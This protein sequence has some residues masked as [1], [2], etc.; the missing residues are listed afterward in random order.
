ME[1]RN[2]G[3]APRISTGPG[4]AGRD[5]PEHNLRA[6]PD[7]PACGRDEEIVSPR[8]KAVLAKRLSRCTNASMPKGE[9]VRHFQIN[10]I[11]ADHVAAADE[12]DLDHAGELAST[13]KFCRKKTYRA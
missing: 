5:C 6:V 8:K 7:C 2:R 9:Y 13:V 11:G 4:Q 10:T 3:S 12:R 1:G